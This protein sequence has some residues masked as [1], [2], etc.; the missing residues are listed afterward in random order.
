MT[1]PAVPDL[2]TPLLRA[3]RRASVPVDAPQPAA[4]E[5]IQTA[6]V[7]I[8]A[9][10]TEPGLPVLFVQRSE[11]VS[12]HQ[13]QIAFPGGRLEPGEGAVEAALRESSEEVGLDPN[14]VEVLGILPAMRTEVHS[15]GLTPVIAARVGKWEVVPDGYEVAEW[16]WV[17]L[18]DLLNAPHEIRTF[19]RN[20]VSRGVH[21]FE[22]EG[23][24]IWGVTGAIVHQLLERL[25]AEE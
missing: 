15:R 13:G 19:E 7:L 17:S 24:V 14:S 10:V 16:F 18:R 2:S 8:V 3:L 9:D 11:K 1:T 5:G 12:T 25:R 4:P 23:R 20:G 21:F 6:A 22:A